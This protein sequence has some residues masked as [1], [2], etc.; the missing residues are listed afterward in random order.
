MDA[1]AISRTLS[2]TVIVL[3]FFMKLPQVRAIYIAKSSR[4]VNI[5][6]YWM[7]M[8]RLQHKCNHIISII[9]AC[10]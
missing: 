9:L 7:D 6:G 8:A 3:S 5:R 4:G 1:L 10:K 2:F